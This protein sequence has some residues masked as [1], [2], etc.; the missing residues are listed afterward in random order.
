MSKRLS[1]PI[2]FNAQHSPMGAFMSFTCG[3]P[4]TKGGIGLQIGQ[5][6]DQE[7]FVGLIDGDR[8]ADAPLQSLPFYIG[9]VS[10]AAEAFTAEQAGPS[11]ANVRPD[12][13]PFALGEIE[14][15]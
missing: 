1:C 3:N 8:Y 13:V 14:R 9:A 15:R 5:P 6:A 7:V 2:G 11:E 12:A 10:K 4:G